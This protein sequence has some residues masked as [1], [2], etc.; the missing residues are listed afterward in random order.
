MVYPVYYCS[1]VAYY[2]ELFDVLPFLY[3]PPI[4]HG[5]SVT[6]GILMDM[7]ESWT[8]CNCT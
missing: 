7:K 6:T 4:A 8:P 1:S 2:D 5:V 3:E